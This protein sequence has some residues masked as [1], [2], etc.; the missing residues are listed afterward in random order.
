MNETF[1]IGTDR[2]VFPE[3]VSFSVNFVHV[4]VGPRP[5]RAGLYR[6]PCF[7]TVRVA[8]HRPHI[9]CYGNP[10][11]PV[12]EYVMPVNVTGNDEPIISR[13]VKQ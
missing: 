4:K 10:F 1:V 9:R 2:R 6:R 13:Y 11:I 7:A 12:A 5:R 3:R 8:T